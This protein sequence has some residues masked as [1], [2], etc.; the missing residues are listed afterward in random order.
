MTA[1]LLPL[2]LFVGLLIGPAGSAGAAE[3]VVGGGVDPSGV[4]ITIVRWQGTDRV[5]ATGR[6]GGGDPTGCEWA[7][8]PAPLG[9]MPPSD[10]PPYRPD[11]YLGLLTCNGV[12]VEVRW[13]GPHNTV[14]LEVEAR[15]L[16]EEHVAH[17]PVPAITVH[18]N[19]MP[20]GLVGLASWF[21]ATGYDG[22]PIVDR[23]D[24]LGIGVD[25]RID[26]TP[27]TWTFGDGATDSGGLGVAYPARS[28]IRHV[29]TEHGQRP[30]SA[31]F[32]LVP[33][34]R[35]DGTAWIELPAIDV[36]DT[37][38]YRIREAQAVVTG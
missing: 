27:T 23:I 24:A 29:Y 20:T 3:D 21:W 31:A 36:T 22:R 19:P 17:V 38:S 15:R 12:G 9:A 7:V 1:R 26:P 4:T 25:V 2:G 8:I 5:H 10:I 13:I 16:V 11:A 30:V 34:Y 37:R 14:D 32:A 18:A 28:P 35:I 33:R 6:D